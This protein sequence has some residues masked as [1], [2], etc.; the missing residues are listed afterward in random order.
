[1][2]RIRVLFSTL[3]EARRLVSEQDRQRRLAQAKYD[4][5]LA[6][7]ALWTYDAPTPRDARW[8]CPLC[9]SV[10]SFTGEITVFTGL[11]FPAC[12][13]FQE[14]HR[15]FKAHATRLGQG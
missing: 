14:G 8:M 1:M 6:F 5:A 7:N 13:G 4:V 11:Q 15:Q 3:C 12:C 9:N 2:S 10:H